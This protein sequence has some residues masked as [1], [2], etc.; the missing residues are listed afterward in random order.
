MAKQ[1]MKWLNRLNFELTL[2]AGVSPEM[3]YFH[4]AVT[5]Y[6]N[7]HHDK[8]DW[9]ETEMFF[10]VTKSH[11]GTIQCFGKKW[12]GDYFDWRE[13]DKHLFNPKPLNE[14]RLVFAFKVDGI[15]LIPILS[16][17]IQW[18]IRF[19]ARNKTNQIG[20][21]QMYGK[22]GEWRFKDGLIRD[23]LYYILHFDDN[24]NFI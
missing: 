23:P 3:T 13:D 6:I 20:T 1:F 17:I 16:T 8:M 21:R 9:L 12:E 22:V 2:I 18:N 5:G 4:K 15:E 11:W 24:D 14:T 7:K 10:N 19:D